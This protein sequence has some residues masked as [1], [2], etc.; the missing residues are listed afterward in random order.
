M[1]L[2]G[3]CA[4]LAVAHTLPIS[5]LRLATDEDYLH[6]ELI[7]NPFELTFLS[8]LDDNHDA[9]LSPA[10]LASHGQAMADRVVS[11]FNLAAGGKL[12][13]AETAGMDPDMNGHHV[14]LRAH[15]RVDARSVPLKME[16]DFN[17][18]TSGSHLTQISYVNGTNIQMAQLD[19][20]SHSVTFDPPRA[21]SKS[22]L[23]STTARNRAASTPALTLVVLFL[24]LIGAVSLS[25]V[26]KQ[27]QP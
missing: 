16:S 1:V 12:L 19:S 9:E 11:A 24:L 26:R 13:V 2:L 22:A 15:Y 7:F 4:P 20:Q 23:P 21:K 10:E 8:E 17:Q 25:L 3:A 14:R 6:F 5:Y 18:L 27:L